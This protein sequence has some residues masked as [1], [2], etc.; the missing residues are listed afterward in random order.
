MLEKNSWLENVKNFL[1]PLKRE[2]Y[3]KLVQFMRLKFSKGEIKNSIIDRDTILENLSTKARDP[4]LEILST[5]ARDTI[6]EKTSYLENVKNFFFPL[7]RENYE[8]LVQFMRFKFSNQDS[9]ITKFVRDRE[10]DFID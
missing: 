1:F 7:K 2:I 9:E 3:E 10:S 5:K 8:K 4:N 6:L